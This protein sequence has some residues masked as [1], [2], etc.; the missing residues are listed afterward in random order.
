MGV[1]PIAI[2]SAILIDLAIG[3]VPTI[4]I[5]LALG[6]V[7]A[8]SIHLVLVMVPM[9]VIDLALGMVVR[10]EVVHVV[11]GVAGVSPV[12]YHGGPVPL[13]HLSRPMSA[14]STWVCVP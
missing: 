10:C 2:A 6:M 4:L 1:L 5:D 11:Y 7:L 13:Q 12:S 3:T 9:I 14:H 8:I